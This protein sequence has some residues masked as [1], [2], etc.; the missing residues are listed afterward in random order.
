MDDRGRDKLF[1]LAFGELYDFDSHPQDLTTNWTLEKFITE[2][3]ELAQRPCIY[4]YD[5]G[6]SWTHKIT[7]MGPET[8]NPVPFLF[9][10]KGI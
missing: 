1:A 4:E 7:F 8:V 2:K 10:G 9:S 6:D 5:F 3:P